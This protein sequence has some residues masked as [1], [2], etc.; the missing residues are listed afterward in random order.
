M[1][2]LIKK[3]APLL[4]QATILLRVT[5]GGRAMDS[6]ESTTRLGSGREREKQF[7]KDKGRWPSLLSIGNLGVLPKASMSQ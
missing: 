6:E 5:V 1:L 7:V 3:V 4:H 2:L